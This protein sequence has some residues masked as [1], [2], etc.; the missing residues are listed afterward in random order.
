MIKEDIKDI[1]EKELPMIKEDIKEIKEIEIPTMKEDIKGIKVEIIEING[2]LTSI[3][4]KELPEIKENMKQMD[5]RL[6]NIESK[7]LPVI[8]SKVD[9][10]IDKEIP[11]LRQ[12]RMIDSNNIAKILELQTEILSRL[13]KGKK[14]IN[15]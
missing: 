4:K 2:R 9:Q 1:K 11:S 5:K 13:P 6:Y 3:E 15:M 8:K 7:E 10:I 12:Q 14:V